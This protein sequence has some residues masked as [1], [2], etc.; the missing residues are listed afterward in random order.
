[1][2]KFDTPEPIT[3]RIE[4]AAGRVRLNATDR[5]DTIMVSC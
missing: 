3:A 1:M 5:D 2:P 4:T